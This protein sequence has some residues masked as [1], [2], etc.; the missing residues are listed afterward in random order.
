[1]KNNPIV[2]ETSTLFPQVPH[3]LPF[4]LPFLQAGFGTHTNLPSISSIISNY[5]P[6]SPQFSLPKALTY[7]SLSHSHILIQTSICLTHLRI[8]VS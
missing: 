1:M 5:V 3:W 2:N 6:F 7:C 8:L 4:C